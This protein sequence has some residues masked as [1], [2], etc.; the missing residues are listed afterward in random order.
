MSRV[1]IVHNPALSGVAQFT[2]SFGVSN[3]R[4]RIGA[5][6]GFDTC[7]FDIRHEKHV[8]EDMFYTGLGRRLTRYSRDGNFVVWDGFI[9]EMTLVQPG[10]SMRISL[11]EMW[12]RAS[13]RYTPIDTGTNPPTESAETSTAVVDDT[14]SQAKYGIKEKYFSPPKIDRM[15]AG[16]AAQY[17]TVMLS[18]YR[19]PK[20]DEDFASGSN[21]SKLTV[22]CEGFMHT[23]G[24]RIYNQ[25]AVSGQDYVYV[26]AGT[27]ITGVGQFIYDTD[28]DTN[29]TQIQKYYNRDNTAL[30]I[31]QAAAGI[32]DNTN[33]RWLFYMLENRILQYKLAST[34]V[35]YI[36]RVS[37]RKQEILD[38]SGRAIPF[39]EVRPNNWL[40]NSDVM[41]HG[42]TP[43][44]MQD[45]FPS[46]FVESVQY[47]E[48]DTLAL[49]GSLGGIA[50]VI[51]ARAADQGDRLL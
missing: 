5:N 23:L 39:Y 2:G 28:F 31:L 27:I 25:T 32:G 29:T 30:D 21:D 14:T 47:N 38:T 40:R 26:V 10:L 15:I 34:A 6:I 19:E 50:Q 20:R 12:N 41:P 11:K 1:H 43:A 4:H 13:V 16:N 46:M 33:R 44:N 36:R 18:Q 42:L 3:Y 8:L 49:A 7:S 22:F 48:P 17:A 35:N 45:D 37:D 24:W 51:I 9:S